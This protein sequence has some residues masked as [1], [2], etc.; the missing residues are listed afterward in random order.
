[1][2]MGSFFEGKLLIKYKLN[3]QIFVIFIYIINI[4]IYNKFYIVYLK[5]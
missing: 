5:K 2:K 4:Y 1:M 3:I